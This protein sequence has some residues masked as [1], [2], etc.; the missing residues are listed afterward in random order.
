MPRRGRHAV[1]VRVRG[2]PDGV[3]AAR[4]R[5]AAHRGEARLGC[6]ENARKWLPGGGP[7]PSPAT[8]Q[9]LEAIRVRVYQR[10]PEEARYRRTCSGGHFLVSLLPTILRKSRESNA[11]RR[12]AWSMET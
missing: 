4:Q 1:A 6:D 7:V 10:R 2:R 9:G 12:V 5:G 11:F 8:P 3:A